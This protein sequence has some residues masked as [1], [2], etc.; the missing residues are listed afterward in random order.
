MLNITGSKDAH[1]LVQLFLMLLNADTLFS[2][3][4]FDPPPPV[5]KEKKRFNKSPRSPICLIRDHVPSSTGH[6]A[7]C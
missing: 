1:Y 7:P 6:P 4:A 3:S 5:N 2:T